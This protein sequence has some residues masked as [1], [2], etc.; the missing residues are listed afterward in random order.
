[1]AIGHEFV[2]RVEQVARHSGARHVVITDLNPQRLELARANGVKC[3]ID[4]RQKSLKDVQREIDMHE[5]FD[6]GMEMSGSPEP[7][8]DSNPGWTCGR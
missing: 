2:G 5:G 8:R 3:A 7:L 1:M 4:P 6:V